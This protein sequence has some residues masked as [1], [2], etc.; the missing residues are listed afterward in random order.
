MKKILL[1][2]L[3]ATFVLLIFSCH[4]DS[5][6]I[7]DDYYFKASKNNADWGATTTTFTIPGDSVRFASVRPASN[8]YLNVTIKFN[9]VGKYL[10]NLGQAELYTAVNNGNDITDRYRRDTTQRDT[11]V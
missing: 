8:E 10:L 7:P 11:L 9:G 5:K 1:P 4:K 2:V 6:V 3:L